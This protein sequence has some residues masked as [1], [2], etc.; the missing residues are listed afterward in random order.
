MSHTIVNDE[1]E[2]VVVFSQEEIDAQLAEKEA[3]I[4]AE[5]ETKLA[6]KDAHVK[7]KLDQFQQ[8]K[9]GVDTAQEEVRAMAEEAKRMAEE[10][11]MSVAQ[12]KE[13]ELATKKDFY[14]QSVV[15]GDT[16]LKKK[17]EDA[18]GM[19][20]LPAATDK[21]IMERVQKAVTLAGI[22]QMSTPSLSFGGAQAPNFQQAGEQGKEAAYE[23]W[24]SE[25][26]IQL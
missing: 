18:Y 16:D 1:G 15:G 24:K 11:K 14:I 19:L 4:K 5:Y 23:A 17:I 8:A 3:A 20:N 6:E 12:A 21:E 13:A 7:D 10:A 25:L 26:G 2:E 9:K 22:S